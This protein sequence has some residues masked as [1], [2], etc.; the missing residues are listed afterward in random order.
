MLCGKTIRLGLLGLVLV[1]CGEN[2]N[3]QASTGGTAATPGGSTGAD[4]GGGNLVGRSA[5]VADEGAQG[6]EAAGDLGP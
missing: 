4:A 1:A 3:G 6:R 5:D 2:A